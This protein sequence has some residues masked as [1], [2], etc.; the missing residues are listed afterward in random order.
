[1]DHPLGDCHRPF[2]CA[3]RP[4]VLR[5]IAQPDVDDR[6]YRRLR[7]R[8]Q[9]FDSQNRHDQHL[10]PS[11]V[12][13]KHAILEA[14]QRRLK[15]IVMTSHHDSGRAPFLARGDMGSD[16]QFPMSLVII[17]GMTVNT[18]VSV[19]FIPLAYYEIYKPRR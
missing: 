2:R 1:M 3:D 6:P 10:A 4:V 7:Y 13:L 18:L 9:R 11:G 12:S 15:A 19:F 5:G 8:H 16:L 17:S 14:G